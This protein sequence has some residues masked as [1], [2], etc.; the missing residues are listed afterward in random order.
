MRKCRTVYDERAPELKLARA[1]IE[2]HVNPGSTQTQL[3]KRMKT[4]QS[5]V[6]RLEGGV[7]IRLSGRRDGSHKPPARHSRSVSRPVSRPA[8]GE[9][10][11]TFTFR[12]LDRSELQRVTALLLK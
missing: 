3:A 11:N 5:V 6:A 4:T 9:D 8:K 1:L 2:V 10:D 7:F 12:G